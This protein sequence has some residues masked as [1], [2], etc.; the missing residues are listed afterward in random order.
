MLDLLNTSHGFLYDDALETNN[1][2]LYKVVGD[3]HPDWGVIC[4]LEYV[5]WSGGRR[6]GYEKTFDLLI[7][8]LNERVALTFPQ[9]QVPL[10]NRPFEV[11]PLTEILRRFEP[12]AAA[13]DVALRRAPET[14]AVDDLLAAF[15]EA[16]GVARESLGLNGSWMLGLASAESN[17][18]IDVI[19]AE[20]SLK[21]ARFLASLGRDGPRAGFNP[22]A[23][24]RGRNSDALVGLLRDAFRQEGEEAY[25]LLGRAGRLSF[26]G[27]YGA[28]PFTLQIHSRARGAS[29]AP[30]YQQGWRF[31][32]R[33]LV[34]ADVT[35]RM[36]LLQYHSPCTVGLAEVEDCLTGTRLDVEEVT[37]WSKRFWYTRAGDRVR[38]LADLI[39]TGSRQRLAVPAFG[40]NW[41]FNFAHFNPAGRL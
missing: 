13:R 40:G 4:L 3:L 30:V 26:S 5:R 20:P 1:G 12:E 19:G 2:H 37:S 39:S 16:S 33:T 25:R 35:D 41:T 11:I 9:W 36:G 29:P 8:H 6:A 32:R 34:E 21:A 28:R 38:F 31:I 27:F 23:P 14:E 15:S 18:N 7:P 24:D 10:Y 22:P 17:V